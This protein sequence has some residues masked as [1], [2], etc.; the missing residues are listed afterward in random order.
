MLKN[1]RRRCRRLW[2]KVKEKNQNTLTAMNSRLG[3]RVCKGFR[4]SPLWTNPFCL[5]ILADGSRF[6]TVI[7]Q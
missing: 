7:L 2:G 6:L 1:G 4:V 5:K 3:I